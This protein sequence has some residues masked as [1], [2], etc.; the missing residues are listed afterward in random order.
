MV[1]TLQPGGSDYNLGTN[2]SATVMIHNGDVAGVSLSA[3]P[4]TVYESNSVPA[5]VGTGSTASVTAL[6]RS[7]PVGTVMLNL[8]N[9]RP[10][11]CRFSTNQLTFTGGT[12]GT[13]QS[14]V[15]FQVAALNNY[16]ADGNQSFVVVL[17]VRTNSTD[18][19]NKYR[20]L[21]DIQ[22]NGTC[23][24][25]LSGSVCAP[26]GTPV[27]WLWTYGLSN[28][29]PAAA[30]CMD[31]D[32]DGMLT[33]QEY[34]AGTNPTNAVSVQQIVSISSNSVVF[35]P[36]LTNRNY[37]VFCITNQSGNS[38]EWLM[39]APFQSSTGTIILPP[40]NVT[41]MQQMYYRVGVRVP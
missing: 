7:D 23:V 20:Q 24:D 8:S 41:T 34:V 33:W 11:K 5:A 1:P 39:V 16:I 13:W 19:Q 15:S 17:Q 9:T 10:D 25:D 38:A 29:S 2:Q 40:T 21:A 30:E 32:H 36:A 37:A 12:N 6:L 26:L 27:S 18:W 3:A 35:S 14:G 22:L 28:V 4:I 31:D